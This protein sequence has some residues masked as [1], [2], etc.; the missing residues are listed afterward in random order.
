MIGARILFGLDR[1]PAGVAPDDPRLPGVRLGA[2][3]L[4]LNTEPLPAAVAPPAPTHA[5]RLATIR[6]WLEAS[7][8]DYARPRRAFVAR[9][10]DFVAAELARHRAELDEGLRRFDGL[11]AAADWTW[12]ALRPLPRAWLPGEAGF[13]FAEIAFWDGTRLHSFSGEAL[14]GEI[15]PELGRFWEGETLPSSPFRRAL[16]DLP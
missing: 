2:A 15:P 7:C 13:V 6:S 5:A 11:Y 3:P 14:G 10:L 12:S 9:Y 1:V 16:P 8:G 4:R